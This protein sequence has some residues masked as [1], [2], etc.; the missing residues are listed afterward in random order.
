VTGTLRP[1]DVVGPA[2]QGIDPGEFGELV[3]AMRSGVTYA[4]VHSSK[5]Q[6]GEIRAQLRTRRH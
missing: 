6:G 5:Y 3:Q 4:N 2:G 1:Q